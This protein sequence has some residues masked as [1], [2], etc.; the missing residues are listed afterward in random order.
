MIPAYGELTIYYDMYALFSSS[1]ENVGSAFIGDPAQL[2]QREGVA[3]VPPDVTPVPEPATLPI[4][5]TVLLAAFVLLHGLRRSAGVEM[6]PLVEERLV[7]GR[8]VLG[9]QIRCIRHELHHQHDHH[10]AFRIHLIRGPIRST[11]TECAHFG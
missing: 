8:Q 5:G 7:Y 4:V 1:S 9:V 6:S 2:V 10:T 11:P 3:F